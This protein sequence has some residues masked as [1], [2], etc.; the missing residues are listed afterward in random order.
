MPELPDLEAVRH[1]LTPRLSGRLIERV[2]VLIPIVVRTS[3]TEFTA[4]LERRRFQ[5]DEPVTRLGKFLLFALEGDFCLVVNPMLTGRFH[6]VTPEMQRDKRTCFTL[7]LDDGHEL[8]YVDE[9]VMGK[10]YLVPTAAVGSLPQISELGPDVLDPTVTE[11]VFAERLQRYSGQI[12]HILTNQRFLAGIGNAYAD[13]ILW[14]AGIHPYRRKTTLTSEEIRRLYQAIHA[15]MDWAIPIVRE[16]MQEDPTKGEWRDHLR[17]HRRGSQP[18]PRC[19]S[20]IVE[21]TAGQRVTNFCRACQPLAS[22]GQQG[23]D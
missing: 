18:C 15:V 23:P 1:F 17:V 22:N 2:T 19:G 8:R 21:I 11:A 20:P 6:Y 14:L 5:T 4:L 7:T 10:V 9:R 13:E 16:K 12:K 3:G